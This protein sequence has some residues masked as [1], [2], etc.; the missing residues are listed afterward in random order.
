MDSLSDCA[1]TAAVLP[2]RSLGTSLASDR[3][4]VRYRR[5]SARALGRHSGR[6]GHHLSPARSAARAGNLSRGS[7]RSFS[8]LPS[9]RASTTSSCT[10][11]APAA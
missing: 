7:R 9:C 1:A 4:L 5:R 2:Q 6:A 8:P 10:T 3:R 11:T